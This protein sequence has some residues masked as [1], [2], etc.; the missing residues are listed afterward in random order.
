MS[1]LIKA[2]MCLFY[3]AIPIKKCFDANFSTSFNKIKWNG[4]ELSRTQKV[5]GIDMIHL[6]SNIY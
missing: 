5:I 1:R 6:I 2:K 4:E 3:Q